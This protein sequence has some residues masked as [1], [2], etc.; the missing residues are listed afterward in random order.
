MYI[1]DAKVLLIT[2]IH[3]N[4]IELFLPPKTETLSYYDEGG[5]FPGRYGRAVL[6]M[7][8]TLQVREFK[9]TIGHHRSRL[10][11]RFLW[12]RDDHYPI[13]IGWPTSKSYRIH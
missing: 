11:W 10:Y 2:R 1:F 13:I 5:Q 7:G 6:Y 12:Q 4:R 9:V 8:K 3:I